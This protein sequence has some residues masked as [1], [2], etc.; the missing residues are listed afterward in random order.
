MKTIIE[1]SRLILREF[2]LEDAQNMFALNQD[3]DVIKYTGDGAFESVDS[4]REFLSK[5]NHYQQHGFGRWPVITKQ[6]NRFIGWCGLKK[7][8]EDFVDIGFRFFKKDWNKGYATESAKACLDYGFSILKLEEIIGRAAK[9]NVASI[10]VL[11]K[12]GMQYW[13]DDACN[14]ISDAVYYKIDKSDYL[15]N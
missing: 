1:T 7:N 2:L 11:E 13:K 14:G 9:A 15:K 10:R 12:L 6:D 4:A 3:F 8:E 5:Y